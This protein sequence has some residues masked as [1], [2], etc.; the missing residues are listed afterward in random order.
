MFLCYASR[1][2]AA[3]IDRALYLPKEWAGD[4]ARRTAAGVPETVTFQ[5]KPQLATTLVLRA[6][7]ARVPCRWV[8]GDEVYGR[9]R[10]LRLALEARGQSFVLAV[11]SDEPLWRDG[12]VY[13]P[14]RALAA[15]LPPEAWQRLSAGDG[16][17]G[18][19]WYDWAWQPVWRLHLTPEERA[20]GHGLLVRR[21]LED[22]SEVA[23]YVVFAPRATTPLETVVRVAGR[24]W[25]IEASFEAAK[26]ECGLD[27]YEV[28]RWEAWHRHITLALLAHAFRV[29]MRRPEKKRHPRRA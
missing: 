12:P 27:E 19:R 5:T 24:R 18:P 6:L 2:G 25:S 8:A 14:A 7:A 10:R 21:S 17:K 9:D 4:E 23:Y 20:W 3:C 26:Q 29:A 15:E 11:G 13:R 28:R 22:P 16:A 1:H